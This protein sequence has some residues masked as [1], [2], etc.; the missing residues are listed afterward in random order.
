M[1]KIIDNV[2]FAD[3]VMAD[4]ED[5]GIAA[6]FVYY[7]LLEMIERWNNKELE[8]D[9]LVDHL[10]FTMGFD[11][12]EHFDRVLAQAQKDTAEIKSMIDGT[13]EDEAK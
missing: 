3:A 2:V 6:S 10:E 13:F 5:R 4:F 8:T 7:E 12:R 11:G 9:K 1:S